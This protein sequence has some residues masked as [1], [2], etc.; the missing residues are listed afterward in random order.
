[1]KEFLNKNYSDFMNNL[2]NKILEISNNNF[3]VKE[4]ELLKLNQDEFSKMIIK[5]TLTFIEEFFKKL[6]KMKIKKNSFLIL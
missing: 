1:M 5:N 4:E 2:V 6:K 3:E